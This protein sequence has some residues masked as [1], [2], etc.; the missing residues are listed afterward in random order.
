MWGRRPAVAVTM[1]AVLPAPFACP[2]A[3]GA[4][5]VS[6]HMLHPDRVTGRESN[7]S[8]MQRPTFPST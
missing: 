3:V 1:I 6:R 7:T 2:Q 4:Q 8:S 5:G